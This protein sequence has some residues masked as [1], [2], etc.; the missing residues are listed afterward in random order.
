MAKRIILFLPFTLAILCSELDIGTDIDKIGNVIQEGVVQAGWSYSDA[1]HKSSPPEG[2]IYFY[3]KGLNLLGS[4]FEV[5]EFH[6]DDEYKDDEHKWL[7]MNITI[8]EKI[9]GLFKDITAFKVIQECVDRDGGTTIKMNITF[10]AFTCDPLTIN[11]L[12]VCG[13]PTKTKDGLS[14]GF[15]KTSSELVSGGVVT[16]SFDGNIKNKNYVVTNEEV[17]TSIFMYNSNMFDKVFF[18]EPYIITDHEVLYP[19]VSGSMAKSGWLEGEPLELVITYNCR[20][21]NGFKEEIILAIELPYFHDLEIHYFKVCGV[22]GDSGISTSTVL[23]I[24]GVICIGLY[25]AF[26]LRESSIDFSTLKENFQEFL[27]RFRR[28]KPLAQRQK[29]PEEAEI[30][31][32]GKIEV[33]VHTLYGTA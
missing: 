17:T 15:S 13:E 12:K 27:N 25:I 16:K 4:T 26:R 30:D 14:I 19:V 29:E 20:V 9:D 24:F 22:K 28:Y 33:N 1:S 18:K 23:I 10:K 21:K 32:F 2:E 5:T 7:F 3:V 11:W 31:D 8:D 6:H